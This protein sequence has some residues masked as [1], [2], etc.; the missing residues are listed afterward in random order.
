LD[1]DHAKVVFRW[2]IDKDDPQRYEHLQLATPQLQTVFRN[3]S[4]QLDIA[5]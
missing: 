1:D 2:K 4:I 5:Q 3:G